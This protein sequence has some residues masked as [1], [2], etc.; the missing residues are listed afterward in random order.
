M[1]LD[2]RRRGGFR[3]L[4]AFLPWATQNRIGHVLYPWS[5]FWLLLI[6]V[7]VT[8]VG[9]PWPMALLALAWCAR[10]AWRSAA[11]RLE[12]RARVRNGEPAERA[13][14]V[15]PLRSTWELRMMVKTGFWWLPGSAPLLG[16]DI[17]LFDLQAAGQE[18]P[19]KIMLAGRLANP[20]ARAPRRRRRLV[21][22]GALWS[23]ATPLTLEELPEL[24]AIWASPRPEIR[25]L[26]YADEQQALWR[27]RLEAETSIREPRKA[28][29]RQ[30]RKA[31]RLF[32]KLWGI[33]HDEDSYVKSTWSEL[34]GALMG[35]GIQV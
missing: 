15:V 30:E 13:L 18:R 6:A 14:W 17:F 23:L 24:K 10:R 27:E 21:R 1:P 4:T 20:L 19:P 31:F 34:Q 12:S 2:R 22:L 16:G 9:G 3:H 5:S 7:S 8:W 11:K 28:H 26:D 25:S 33:A 29:W 35:A 32:H